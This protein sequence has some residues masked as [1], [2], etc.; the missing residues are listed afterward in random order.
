MK[1]VIVGGDSLGEALAE[2]LIKE[3]ND[4]V[5]IEKEEKLAEVLAEKLDALVLHGD[6]SDIK[7]LK[8]ADYEN[9]DAIIAMTGDD[10]TNLMVCEMAKSGGVKN[11][12]TRINDSSNETIFT[13]AGI[14]N[15]INTTT[16]AIMAFKR[17]L[18]KPGKQLVSLV[19]GGKGQIFEVSVKKGSGFIGKSVEDVSNGFIICSLYRDDDLVLPKQKTKIKEGDIITI[20]SPLKNVKRIEKML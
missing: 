18:E 20:C 15:I 5:I 12:L 9:S 10:K 4:I 3:K 16:A 1:V 11:I 6:G 17:A 7:I 2:A 14:A 19:G 13:K 8:D